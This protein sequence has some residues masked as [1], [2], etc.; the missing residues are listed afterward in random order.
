[1]DSLLAGVPQGSI[2][3]SLF[4]LIYISEHLNM[5]KAFHQL[6]NYLLMIDLSFLLSVTNVSAD[7]MNKDLDKISE[8]AYQWMM[9]FNPD[10]FKQAQEITFSKKKIYK[11]FTFPSLLY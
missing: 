6:P 9:S 4:F 8:W 2:L 3:G 7:Q 11:C 10:I 5:L 1:M